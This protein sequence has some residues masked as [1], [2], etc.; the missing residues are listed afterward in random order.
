MCIFIHISFKVLNYHHSQIGPNLSEIVFQC[1]HVRRSFQLRLGA[2]PG[3]LVWIKLSDQYIKQWP[4]KNL[5]FLLIQSTP[6]LFFSLDTLSKALQL[7]LLT[8]HHKISQILQKLRNQPDS[9]RAGVVWCCCREVWSDNSSKSIARRAER[10]MQ[11]TYRSCNHLKS[12]ELKFF[13]G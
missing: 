10:N 11:S 3:S 12:L 9:L 1:P 7:A 5:K 8:S 6:V 2:Q 4:Q 13:Q